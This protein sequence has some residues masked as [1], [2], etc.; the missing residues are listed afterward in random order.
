[1]KKL[2]LALITLTLIMTGV[3][4][5][6]AQAEY[7]TDKVEDV[8]AVQLRKLIVMI[9]EPREKMLNRIEKKPKLG[10]V[11]DYK[12]D[13][14][15]YNA[16][17]KAVIEKFWP[18]HKDGIQY[19]T[20]DEIEA[21]KITKSKEYVVV[22]CLSVEPDVTLN[23]SSGFKYKDGLM[24]EKDINVDF[25]NRK[26]N[27]FSVFSIS[28]IENFGKEAVF[29]GY[30]FDVF[31]IKADLVVSMQG[32]NDKLYRYIN[33]KKGGSNL[34]DAKEA[35]KTELATNAAKLK[36]KTLI[37]RAEWLDKELTESNFKDYYPHKYKICDR[38][39]MDEIVMS[40][41]KD[42]AYGVVLPYVTPGFTMYFQMIINA[43][44]GKGMCAVMPST[45]SMLAA[46]SFAGHS[47]NRNFT[48]KAMN[49]I[50]DQILGKK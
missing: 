41:N 17:M 47:G 39:M 45:S 28:T 14:E 6:N 29:Q 20:F 10:S 49:Q 37:I 25:E 32:L 27:M 40:Q 5:A 30:L 21:I 48:I 16:N 35:A 19:K 7:V 33:Y 22:C 23:S 43:E 9:E 2:K 24:W 4:K 15:K 8:E 26:D 46:N 36:D 31:P 18:Y 1:M 44:D 3:V 13:L 42:Y 11:A 38:E 50:H 34:K 12:A